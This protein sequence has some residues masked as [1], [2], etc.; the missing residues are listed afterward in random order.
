MRDFTWKNGGLLVVGTLVFVLLAGCGVKDVSWQSAYEDERC[1]QLWSESETGILQGQVADSATVRVQGFPYLRSNR[2]LEALA[3]RAA[4]EQ[5]RHHVLEQMRLLDLD[6]RLLEHSRIPGHS[7]AVLGGASAEP[8]VSV[9]KELNRCSTQLLQEDRSRQGFFEEVRLGVDMDRDYS[10]WLRSVGLYPLT[11]LLVDYIAQNAKEEMV[12]QLSRPVLPGAGEAFV[13]FRPVPASSPSLPKVSELLRQGRDNPLLSLNL[14]DQDLLGLAREF[15]PLLT[16][17]DGGGQDRFGRIV[18]SLDTF[19]VDVH[20][21]VVYYYFSQTFVQGIPALQINY[22]IWFAQRTAPAPWFEQGALDG[23]IFRVTLNWQGRPIFVDVALQCGCYHFV[24]FDANL[25]S[26]TLSEPRGFLPLIG[27]RLPDLQEAEHLQFRINSGWHQIGQVSAALPLVKQPTYQLLPYEG[28]E[29]FEHG[30]AVVS[31]FDKEGR[32]PGTNRLERFFL[33]PMGI[34]K[35]GAMR[36]RGRQPITLI[37]RA[38]FDDPHLFDNA[39]GYHAPLPGIAELI[40]KEG[41]GQKATSVKE[42]PGK[43]AIRAEKAKIGE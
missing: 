31:L 7:L 18:R 3:D 24:L 39:F 22:A 33:F 26:G 42:V 41:I 12:D 34:E 2:Y 27:G 17:V 13:T 21:P 29:Y 37:G 35:V 5:E 8:P 19:A 1:Q 15:A 14:A 25:V 6:K 30:S 10:L 36:Q 43:R 28:L 32:V 11:S 16:I 23:L 40:S 9:R 38:Y 20:D 4:G